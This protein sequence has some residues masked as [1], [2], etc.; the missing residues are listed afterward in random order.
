MGKEMRTAGITEKTGKC[1]GLICLI[2]FGWIF[3]LASI[4]R[5]K[6]DVI[7]YGILNS[8]IALSVLHNYIVSFI[9][10]TIF[11]FIIF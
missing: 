8:K 5:R 9:I 1:W 7:K 2:P 10:V 6:N 11:I 4:I 3:F